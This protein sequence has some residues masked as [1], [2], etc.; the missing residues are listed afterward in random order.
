[1]GYGSR[2]RGHAKTAVDAS[3]L[4]SDSTNKEA[5]PGGETGLF[6]KSV[7]KNQQLLCIIWPTSLSVFRA[8]GPKSFENLDF[9]QIIGHSAS[10]RGPTGK[11]SAPKM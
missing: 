10:G 6:G 2:S 3:Q 4:L 1:M 8:T 11:V 7:Q 5:T 9:L